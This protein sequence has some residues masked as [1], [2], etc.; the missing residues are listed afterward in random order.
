MVVLVAVIASPFARAATFIYPVEAIDDLWHLASE[1]FS[2]KYAGINISGIGPSDEGWY[3]RYKHENLTY[4]FGPLVD[5][6]AARKKKWELEAVRD[7][8]IRNRATLATSKVDYVRFTFSGVYG[9]AGNSP[10]SVTGNARI[11]KDGRSGP[12]GDM[13]GDGIPNSKD[14]DMDGDGISNDQD[15]DID[16]DGIPNELDD[17]AFG[18]FPGR[19][20]KGGGGKDGTGDGKDGE[21]GAGTGKDGKSGTGDSKDGTDTGKGGKDG[22]G[23]GKEGTGGK[24]GGDGRLAGAGGQGADGS[25]SGAGK[26]KGGKSSKGGSTGSGSGDGDDPNGIVGAGK[27]GPQKVASAKGSSGSQRGGSPGGQSGGQGGQSGQQGGQS[28]Q[29]G[30]QSGQQG[31]QSGSQGGSSGQSGGQSGQQGQGGQPGGGP[32]GGGQGG[33]GNPL[34]L[35]GSL[36][37][38]ILGL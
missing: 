29:Q 21:N 17:Y 36:L 7:A 15:R 16:G 11:S 26:G 18:T 5:V 23:A 27:D 6:E 4:M 8:A 19:D 28:G 13:D 31:G 1:D 34:Q 22:T 33:G 35:I 14:S 20:G 3:V 38:A 9:K 32:S 25:G 24:S 30:G 10:Y 12:D 2:A 37:K